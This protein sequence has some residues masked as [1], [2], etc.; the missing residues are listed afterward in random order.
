[1]F[2]ILAMITGVSAVLMGS[3]LLA[4]WLR[5]GGAAGRSHFRGFQV[6]G[7]ATAGVVALILLVVYLAAVHTRGMGWTSVALLVL[8]SLLGA[9][10]FLPWWWRG[11]QGKYGDNDP[12]GHFP[13]EDH[14]S[15]RTVVIHG[16][17]ADSTA[18][19]LAIAILLD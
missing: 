14:F 13:A 6:L 17:L 11:R 4:I 8:A 15:L 7:H 2:G 10:M 3:V 18:V 9:T 19:L 1:M 12:S 16:L 5:H